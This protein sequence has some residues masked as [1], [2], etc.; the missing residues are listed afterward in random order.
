MPRRKAAANRAKVVTGAE[1]K[2]RVCNGQ[3][4]QWK[5]M[6]TGALTAHSACWH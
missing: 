5:G 3:W 1:M 6:R 2:F 4:G